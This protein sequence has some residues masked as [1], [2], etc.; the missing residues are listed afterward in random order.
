MVISKGTTSPCIACSEIKVKKK[1]FETTANKLIGPYVKNT[2]DS[3]APIG[4]RFYLDQ[5]TVKES[6]E[7]FK[8]QKPNMKMI[9]EGATQ[10]KIPSFLAKK[11][12]QVEE[13]CQ[14]LHSFKQKGFPV[15]KIR[16]DNA[17]ENVKLEEALHSRYWKM[18]DVEMEYTSRDSPQQNSIAEL[19]IFNT[20]LKAKTMMKA[21]NVPKKFRYYLFPDAVKTSAKLDALY[22]ITY[23]DIQQTRHEHFYGR[24][25]SYV[26][27][28]RT[29]SEAGTV[30]TRTGTD[31]KLK[32]SSGVVCVMVGYANQHSGD[33]YRM[34]NPVTRY[35]YETRDVQ[36]LGRMYWNKPDESIEDGYYMIEVAD[37]LDNHI[38]ADDEPRVQHPEG[39][40]EQNVPA[41]APMQTRTGRQVKQPALLQDYETGFFSKAEVNYCRNLWE[42]GELSMY[43]LGNEILAVGTTGAEFNNTTELKPMKYE[44]AMNRQDWEEWNEAVE[45]EH[46]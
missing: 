43:G 9:V 5:A 39:E 31:E 1:S 41:L 16:C 20:A 35:V 40:E 42:I 32:E 22:L 17:G 27:Y 3:N 4:T 23:N 34:F 33:T 38:Q 12:E 13:T 21:A 44:D 26:K 11:S 7:G 6:K 10:L 25:P 30:K 28:L 45:A 19:A 15:L 18:T 8:M 46:D 14:Q 2:D 29:W 36:W 24:L 37:Q